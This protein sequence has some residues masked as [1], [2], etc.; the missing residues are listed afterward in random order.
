LID[1]TDDQHNS[2]KRC[3]DRGR[4]GHIDLAP[5]GAVSNRRSRCICPVEF[6][7]CDDDAAGVLGCEFS[8]DT[9]SNDPASARDENPLPTHLSMHPVQ[10]RGTAIRTKHRVA[11][12]R[13]FDSDQYLLGLAPSGGP[14]DLRNSRADRL[15]QI[16]APHVP[17]G[18]MATN[19]DGS[20]T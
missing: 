5:S 20:G 1:A 8:G 18:S 17:A 15:M 2:V 19:I 4:L 16:K 3:F 11:G 6:A 13:R 14:I 10:A 9:P 12:L 7:A